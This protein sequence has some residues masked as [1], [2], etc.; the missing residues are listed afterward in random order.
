LAH[1]AKSFF[2]PLSSPS[3]RWPPAGV[4]DVDVNVAR[5]FRGEVFDGAQKN[6]RSKDLSYMNVNIKKQIQKRRQDAG[7]TKERPNRF[8]AS[9]RASRS[10]FRHRQDFHDRLPARP[11]LPKPCRHVLQSRHVNAMH[12]L[13][14]TFALGS[15]LA[16]SAP[17]QTAPT[18]DLSGTWKLN[19]AK[20][21]LDKHNEIKSETITITSK[22]AT[23]EFHYSTNGKERTETYTPDGKERATAEVKGGENVAKAT[24]KKSVLVIEHAGY[25]KVSGSLSSLNNSEIYHFTDRWT[26]SSDG[27][28]LKQD[29]EGF[30]NHQVFV[31]DK[32]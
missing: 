21:K 20:S 14:L 13:L 16:S 32:Q 6:L 8:L 19:L 25:L 9:Q 15:A 10:N 7:A 30:D 23:I 27:H 1:I 17:A 24:W 3:Y 11:V 18:P 22:D 12:R 28:T 29:S 31:Y 4:F 26:L 2:S 5:L